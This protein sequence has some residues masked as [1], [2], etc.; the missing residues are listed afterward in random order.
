[1]V[2]YLD[3]ASGVV[4]KATFETYGCPPAIAAGSYVTDWM[5]GKP[6]SEVAALNAAK[7]SEYLGGVPVG[8][9]HCP[10]LAVACV[11]DALS[12]YADGSR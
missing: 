12:K 4:S 1:M 9:E 2:I 7:L 3:I 5:N 6:L 8:K 10:Q 11:K